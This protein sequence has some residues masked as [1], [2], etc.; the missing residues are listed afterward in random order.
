M[1]NE[2]RIALQKSQFELYYQPQYDAQ[3]HNIIG[4][5]ALLRW[6]HPVKGVL[7]PDLFMNVAESTGLI[8][9]IGDWVLRRACEQTYKWQQQCGC[10]Y[11][12]A[13]NLS[14]LQFNQNYLPDRV[15][16][17]LA[18]TSLPAE[19]L[20][21]EITETTMMKDIVETI[22]LLF[23][24]KKLG[25]RLAIDDFGTGY[26]SMNYLKNF[27]I[28]TLKIDRSFVEEI[29][30]NLKDAAIAQTIVQLANNLDLATIA[31]G[32]ETEEQANM[33]KL[34]GCAEFQG[35][36]F[37]KPMPASEIERLIGLA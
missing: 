4:F 7:T 35:Y 2:L 31:E 1:E 5:E 34:M 6:H 37:S 15:R 18:E 8:L 21:L 17:T 30:I 29:V 33:L 3:S 28:D 26:S 16:Q 19:T 10:A 9:P 27:P 12:I 20:E 25:V 32:V 36:Y 13:V 14:A 11:R 22:S 24:M 23:S